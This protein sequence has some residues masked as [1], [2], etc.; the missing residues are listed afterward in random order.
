MYWQKHKSG[1]IHIYKWENG[2]VRQLPRD[3]SRHLDGMD[4][5]VVNNFVD[6]LRPR[7]TVERPIM[8]HKLD[9]LVQQFLAYKKK[10]GMNPCTL[11]MK[12]VSLLN[13]VI[14]YFLT[15]ETP[16]TDPNSW[17][18]HSIA[19]LEYMEGKG[20]S[21]NLIV[22]GGI[23]LRQFYRWLQDEKLVS[24]TA[25]LPL[26]RP[27]FKPT[28]TPLQFTITPDEVIAFAKAQTD[29]QI[30]FMAL[31]GFF[32]S[33][34]PQ[35]LFALTKTDFI[36]GSSAAVF[37]ACK[38]MAKHNL[39]NKFAVNITKQNS[40]GAKDKKAAPKNGSK[41][42]VA[43]FNG[44]AAKMLVGLIK[45]LGETSG[46]EPLI[47]FALDWNFK[48]WSAHGIP[49]ITLKDLR[50]ASIYW[51]GHY[52][53]LGFIELKSHARHKAEST[54][55]LYLRRPEET[56]EAVNELDLDA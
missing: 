17:P 46:E 40:K 25:E 29:N 9:D 24:R 34:R 56:F 3:I 54:T 26:R 13:H 5:S 11:E 51:L 43:C 42:V 7:K 35:E 44:E 50:R 30:A 41:G 33:L 31:A 4:D 18:Q 20:F 2:K 21:P 47:P 19:L 48:R 36:A 45:A 6:S 8:H 55:S 32:F 28:V 12:R 38:V 37:E 49:G 52:T 53:S 1:R 22:R 14:P 27:V 15:L 16:A 23:A 10:R 39:F